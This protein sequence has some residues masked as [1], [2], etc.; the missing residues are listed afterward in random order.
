MTQRDVRLMMTDLGRTIVP[1][2]PAPLIVLVEI[3]R[4]IDP[5]QAIEPRDRVSIAA[6]LAKIVLV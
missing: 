2:V 1:P 6:K 4:L 5:T 3:L